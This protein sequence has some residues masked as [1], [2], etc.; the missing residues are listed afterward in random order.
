MFKKVFGL[1]MAVFLVM[2][3]ISIGTWAY[4][5]DTETSTGNILA[6]GTLDLKTNDADGVSQTLSAT[7]MRPGETI[8][9]EYIFLKN[10][11]SVDGSSIDIVFSYV[12]N[13]S[14]PNPVN[15]SANQTAAVIELIELKYGGV[16]ILGNVTDTNINGYR[17]IQD[18]VSTN[19]NGQGG[20]EAS[21]TK[22]FEIKIRPRSTTN[23][24][25][26]ADGITIT[27]NFTLNQ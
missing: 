11:G 26:Q 8:G 5:S 9:P 12:E 10:S 24:E 23:K 22:Q 19:L 20:I 7:N 27:M 18:L 3:M 13:D 1:T 25:F 4:F 6:A 15:K 17:D 21:A 16:S 2:G 14:S